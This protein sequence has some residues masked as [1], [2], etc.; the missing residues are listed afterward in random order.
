MGEIKISEGVREIANLSTTSFPRSSLLYFSCFTY[1]LSSFSLSFSLL[2]YKISKYNN[3]NEK[4]RKISKPVG[5]TVTG[6]R[7]RT[8]EVNRR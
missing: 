8:Q 7:N 5:K 1:L 6:E 2:L 4:I 3:N